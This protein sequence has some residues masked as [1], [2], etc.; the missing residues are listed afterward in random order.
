M[1]LE[2]FNVDGLKN[3]EQAKITIRKLRDEI[4]LLELENQKLTAKIQYLQEQNDIAIK[5]STNTPNQ[6]TQIYDEKLALEHAWF[7]FGDPESFAASTA[8]Q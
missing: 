2:D 5:I 3:L 6:A 7:N 8:P 1:S 4:E